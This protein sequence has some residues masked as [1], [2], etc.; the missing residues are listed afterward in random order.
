MLDDKRI[1]YGLLVG[2]LVLAALAILIDPIRGLVLYLHPIQI[3]ALVVG[4]LV[5]LAGAYAAFVR[6]PPPAA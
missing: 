6:K 1:Q 5:F 2:G 4:I 3:V